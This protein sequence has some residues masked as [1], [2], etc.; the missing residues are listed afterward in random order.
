MEILENSNNPEIVFIILKL[1][2]SYVKMKF[3]SHELFFSN[4][5]DVSKNKLIVYV[6]GWMLGSNLLKISN[7]F[8]FDEKFSDISEL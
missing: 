7:I 1:F 5:S 3:K 2:F 8:S 6:F 4:M